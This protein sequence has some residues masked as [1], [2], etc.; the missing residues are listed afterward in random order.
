MKVKDNI[1][2]P[3]SI[4]K[5][6]V[7]KCG[8]DITICGNS[9]E[10]TYYEGEKVHIVPANEILMGD[11]ICYYSAQRYIIHRV[12]YKA[13]GLLLTKGDNNKYL[14]ALEPDIFV[15]GKVKQ[16]EEK[17]YISNEALITYV[18]WNENEYMEC[19]EIGKKLGATMVC[20]NSV[21]NDGINIAISPYSLQRITSFYPSFCTKKKIYIHIGVRLSD[22]NE[23]G[24]V[25]DSCFDFVVRSGNYSMCH[26]LNS[27]EKFAILNNEMN[28][29]C[30]EE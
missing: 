1:V 16:A 26:Y 3:P 7:E 21:Y 30:K 23:E 2:I 28:I 19:K 11:V 29:L 25:L 6:M 4:A 10:P 17:K 22:H 5:K 12:I 18:F 15:I 24:F 13:N 9:M 20:A 27:V 8:L 14:D